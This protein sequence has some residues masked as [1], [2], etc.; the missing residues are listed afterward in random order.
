MR[1]WGTEP[2]S[3][4][5]SQIIFSDVLVLQFKINLLVRIRTSAFC[6]RTES[7]SFSLCQDRN[8]Y[9]IPFLF[10]SMNFFYVDMLMGFLL[11][12][13]SDLTMDLIHVYHI[14]A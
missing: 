5:H 14:K 4:I 6:Y 2:F 11:L 8:V 9:G 12:F 13:Y 7:L 3:V 10:F 1:I